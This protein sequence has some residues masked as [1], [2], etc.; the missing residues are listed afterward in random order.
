MNGVIRPANWPYSDG[1]QAGFG[2]RSS[3]VDE[4]VVVRVRQVHGTTVI[5]ADALEPGVVH[6]F[7]GD[8]LVATKPGIVAAVVTADCVPILLVEPEARWTAAVHAGWRGTLAGI[9]SSTLATARQDGI[10]PERLL[11]AIG[12]AIGDCC[13][14]VGDEVA[15][16]F[17]A[18][19]LPVTRGVGREKATLNLR[20][21]NEHLLK[22][23]GLRPSRIQICG[24]CTRC[25]ARRYH[26]YRADRDGAG[27]QLSWI[28][29]A[30]RSP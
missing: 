18:A 20:A 17:V 30:A 24:P 3:S 10:V 26:S 6:D 25:R 19:G 21:C 13:Y 9:V 4:A 16:S 28:G 29:W 2:D 15:E 1:L 12:P 23:A 11:A 14:E 8:A 7:P 27:R 22:S 5:R